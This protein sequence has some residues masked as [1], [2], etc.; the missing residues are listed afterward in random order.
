VEKIKKIN[1]QKVLRDVAKSMVRLKR[2]ERLLKMITRF[3]D[4]EFGLSHTSLLVLEEERRRFV[5]VD[6]KGERRFPVRLL[7]FEIDHPMVVWFQQTRRKYK[8]PEDFLHL[9]RV[10]KQCSNH[11]GKPGPE[12]FRRDLEG[13]KK[14]MRDLKAEL[15]IPGYYKESLIGLLLLGKKMNGRPFTD[16]EI[17]FFQI[18]AQDCS[19]AIKTAQYHQSL[20]EQN[21]ALAKQI[22]E[23]G[24]LRKKEQETYYQIM[25]SLAQEVHAKDP[26]TFGHVNQVERLGMMT[27]EEMG[28]DLSGKKR[29]VL[30]AGLVLHDVGKIGIPDHILKKPDRLTPEEW[31]IM[32]THSDKGAKILEPLTDFKE[33]AE[34]VRC[35]HENFDGS[36]YPRGLKGE[37]I[38][39]EARIVSVVDAFH[40]IVSNRCYD[41]A[42]SVEAGFQELERCAGTQ[43]DPEVVR[44]FIR[45]LKRDMEKRGVRPFME[46]S[47]KKTS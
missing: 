38:P 27:A 44:A 5:F 24:N 29:D 35:H 14:A 25:R 33:V 12:E 11:H 31:E 28:L 7:K 13:V 8:S 37:K 10:E 26:Y 9:P 4:R 15:V 30:S 41:P 43:F 42:R 1:Y 6:S 3:I 39:I 36:G 18:L 47:E 45:A 34:I 16:S 40:S 21:E 23:I 46:E 32:K 2:P 17:S 19:M 22:E 20:V